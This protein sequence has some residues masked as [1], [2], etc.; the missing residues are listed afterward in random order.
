MENTAARHHINEKLV[1]LLIAAIQFVNILDFMIVMPLGPEFAGQLGIGSHHLGLIAGI[2]T[3]AGAVAGIAGSF[4]LDRFDRR[5]ALAVSIFGLMVGTFLGGLAHDL[6]SLLASRVIAGL[7]GGPATSLSL[8]I[9]S[10]VVPQERRGRAMGTVMAGFSVASIAG[11][12]VALELAHVFDTWRA[13]FFAVAGLGLAIAFAVIALLPPLRVHL[14]RGVTPPGFAMLKQLGKPLPLLAYASMAA[15]MFS[16]FT[17][18][19]NIPTYLVVNLGYTGESWLPDAL[20]RVGID[21][22]PSVLGPLYM[23][24]GLLSLLVMQFVGR[25]TDRF[26][27]TTVSWAGAVLLGIVVYVW[28]VQYSPVIPVMVLFVAFMGVSSLRGVPAR[29]LDSKIPAP[30]DRASFM[31]MQ[32]A[33]QHISLAM[34]AGLS[35]LVLSEAADKK[36]VGMDTMAW[37]S[38]VFIVLLPMFVMLAERKLKRRDAAAKMT[39]FTEPVRIAPPVFEAAKP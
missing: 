4:F 22:H 20:A 26:G 21:Y 10:D 25:V 7:F 31:S 34:A 1:V 12:P 35:S 5:K 9:I 23:F 2:Y 14:A 37:I 16:A 28:F 3:A 24:G 27:S 30:Q 39:A 6:N 15:M 19:P 17:L 18:I 8:A 32:S 36:L 29:T 38:M 11:V 13:P 33:V